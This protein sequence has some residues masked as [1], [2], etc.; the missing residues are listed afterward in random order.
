ML[1]RAATVVWWIGVLCIAGGV[2]GM[3]STG[4][5]SDAWLPLLMGAVAAV[6]FFSAA[7]ILGGTFWRPPAGPASR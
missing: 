5:L 3:F 1:K 7:F 6:V 2:V 4:R